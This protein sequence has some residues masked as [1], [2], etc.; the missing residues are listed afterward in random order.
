MRA[1][2]QTNL[3]LW[4]FFYYIGYHPYFAA[5]V[6]IP[7]ALL[8]RTN[9]QCNDVLYQFG[10][11]NSDHHSREDFAE[12][13]QQAEDMIAK[14]LG[15]PTAPQYIVAEKQMYPWT[16]DK[17]AL[18]G[19]YQADAHLKSVETKYRQIQAIGVESLTQVGNDEAVTYSDADG[20]GIDDTFTLTATVTAGTDESSIAVFFTPADRLNLPLKEYEIRPVRV[21]ISGVTATITGPR[22]LMVLPALTLAFSPENLDVTDAG[23]FVTEVDVYTRTT[24]PSNAGTLIWE[25]VLSEVFFAWSGFSCNPPCTVEITTACFGTRN[26]EL[27]LVYP[28]PAQYDADTA[29]FTSVCPPQW[30][31]PDR[32]TINYLAGYPRDDDGWVNRRLGRATTLLAISLMDKRKCGCDNVLKY[33]AGLQSLP[34]TEQGNLTVAQGAMDMASGYFGSQLRGAVEAANLLQSMEG[35]GAVVF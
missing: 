22:A 18:T 3:S 25:N 2:A 11:Q 20:D 8:Q 26:A 17:R 4:E 13:I 30:R 9:P 35:W 27:G 34:I 24:D 7:A 5:Q 15:Y 33:I 12:A 10:Y 21:S 31:A 32:F 23:N 14:L 6:G 19:F 1:S 29:A 28:R 16:Y